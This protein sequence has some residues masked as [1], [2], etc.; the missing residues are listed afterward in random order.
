[1]EPELD[2]SFVP[3]SPSRRLSKPA[4]LSHCGFAGSGAPTAAQPTDPPTPTQPLK[5]SINATSSRARLFDVLLNDE[6]CAAFAD[7]RRVC[8]SRAPAL[9]RFV[10]VLGSIGF[11][12]LDCFTYLVRHLARRRATGSP[13]AALA[14]R[15]RVVG[16]SWRTRSCS[17]L[18]QVEMLWAVV[19]EQRAQ[20]SRA[21]LFPVLLPSRVR[22]REV[23]S[24]APPLRVEVTGRGSK[25]RL[26]GGSCESCGRCPI[27]RFFP[28][29][30]LQDT[31]GSAGALRAHR[32]A[33][34]CIARDAPV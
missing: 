14:V 1:M 30:G 18:A 16:E 6:Q 5:M 9:R 10:A 28:H 3:P 13:R 24:A 11:R 17:R 23:R 21:D 22:S 33:G 7:A 20:G 2:I 31:A 8:Q 34:P 15:G 12:L 29:A 4:S 19:L 32:G 25:G 26:A 27:S